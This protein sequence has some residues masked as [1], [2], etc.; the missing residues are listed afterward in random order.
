MAN[1]RPQRHRF[2]EAK[3]L[4]RG[5]LQLQLDVVQ[6]LKL[7]Y[8]A[9]DK[10]ACRARARGNRHAHTRASSGKGVIDMDTERAPE[11]PLLY[12]VEETKRLVGLGTT[13]IY[14]L[15]KD[16][17]LERVKCGTRTPIPKPKAPPIRRGPRPR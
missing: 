14:Q 4:H 8:E 15:L 12:S 17:A 2:A 13:T 6:R 7:L 5:C 3:S 9:A 10:R 1:L 16:G 11:P